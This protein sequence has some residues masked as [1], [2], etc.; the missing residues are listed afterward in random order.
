MKFSNIKKSKLGITLIEIL[1]YV[2]L[3]TTVLALVTNF[4]YQVANFRM[5]NQIQ[6]SVF[7]NSQLVF[8]KIDQ[9]LRQADEIITPNTDIFTDSLVINSLE[10]Q[11]S[12]ELDN[13]VLKKNS[14]ALTDEFVEVFFDENMGFRKIGNTVQL[15]MGVRSKMKPFGQPKQESIYKSAFFIY[16]NED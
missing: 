15:I 1:I 4:L 14:Q 13:G 3:L 6:S 10:G 16:Q 7:Q 11:V 8:N 12:F 9:D 2:G 5:L